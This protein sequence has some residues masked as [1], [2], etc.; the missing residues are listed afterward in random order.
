MHFGCHKR[1]ITEFRVH[2]HKREETPS[3]PLSLSQEKSRE[4]K[5]SSRV[6]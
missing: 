1:D 6:R 5:W 3:L 2:H 4:R